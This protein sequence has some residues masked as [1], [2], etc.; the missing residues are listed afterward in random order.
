MNLGEYKIKHGTIS[1]RMDSKEQ[2]KSPGPASYV[3][4]LNTSYKRPPA[5]TMRPAA[6]AV[7]QPSDQWTPSPNMY[8]PY[9]PGKK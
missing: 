1:P 4:Y 5:Y 8:L 7:Y 3:P 9:I 6:R 2:E